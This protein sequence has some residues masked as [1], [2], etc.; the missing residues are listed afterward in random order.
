MAPADLDD[1]LPLFL[2]EAGSRLDRLAELLPAA[3]SDLDAAVQ[4]RRELHAL[5]GASRLMGMSTV[6]DL[7]HQAEDGMVEGT[8]EGITDAVALV[9]RISLLVDELQILS[10]GEPEPAVRTGEQGGGRPPSIRGGSGELRVATAVVD[11]LAETGTRMRI[12]ARS[13]AAPVDR[14]FELATAAEQRAEADGA[15]ATAAELGGQ[16]RHVAL[17]LE[18]AVKRLQRLS[19]EQLESMLRLQLQPLRPFLRTLA[20]HT[21]EVAAGLDK[22]VAVTTSGGDVQLD[23]RILEAIREA[24][25]HLAYNAVDHGIEAPDERVAAGKSPQGHVHFGAE[26]EGDRVRLVVSDDGRGIDADVV[27]RVA[28][29]RGLVMPTA[30]AHLTPTDAYRLLELPGF[31]TRDLA[32]DVSGRGVGLDAVAAS[33]RATGGDLWIRS[34]VG[35]GTRI[36]IELPVARRGER[37]LV[38]EVGDLT[39]A[40][41]LAA[42]RSFDRLN[43]AILATEDDGRTVVRRADVELPA[44]PLAPLFGEPL[45]STATLIEAMVGGRIT[46]L[47]VDRIV[48]EEE[49]IVRSLPSVAGAPPVIEGI[50]LLS[51]GLPVAVLSLRRVGPL[52]LETLDQQLRIDRPAPMRVLLTDDNTATREM[53]RRL[54]EDGGFEVEAVETAEQALERIET[55]PFHCVITGVELPGLNGIELTRRVRSSDLYSDLPVVVLSTRDRPADRLAG[56]EAGADGYLTKQGLDPEHLMALIRRLG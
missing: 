2:E 30:A 4:V 55:K 48:G 50:A 37:V 33:F 3:K 51:G 11:A 41:P 27:L 17:E 19:D 29:E 20:R 14:L 32:T 21:R 35:K 47:I 10:P 54:L 53:I 16:L 46:A 25:L 38:V 9:E 24:A 5:K 1:L 31:T 56:L 43:P 8:T 44:V 28:V 40:I 15:P 26:T 13:A 34:D 7:C 22:D 12:A 18:R 45:R 42:I 6:A 23:R 52:D 49:V 39:L 36:T